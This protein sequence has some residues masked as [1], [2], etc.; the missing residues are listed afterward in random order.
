VKYIISQNTKYL[1]SNHFFSTELSRRLGSV[2]T[3]NI[4][5]QQKKNSTGTI[6]NLYPVSN[7]TKSF[8]GSTQ[9]QHL[10]KL[11]A[12]LQNA[13][14]IIGTLSTHATDYD[15]TRTSGNLVNFGT[16]IIQRNIHGPWNQL[17]DFGNFTSIPDV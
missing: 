11:A 1:P 6:T 15:S 14:C 10:V 3:Y 5:S 7:F 2:G 17:S 9:V 8:V 16:K 13:A 4:C 12:L